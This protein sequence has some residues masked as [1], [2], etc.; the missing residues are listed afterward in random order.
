MTLQILPDAERLTV[1]WLR[2]QPE[3]AAIFDDRIYTEIPNSP[4][5]PLARVTRVAGGPT[6][7]LARLDSPLLQLDVWGGPKATA[8]DGIA[9]LLALMAGRMVGTHD[10]GV[11]SAVEVGG[12]SWLPDD[13]Y[14]PAR[15]RY[16]A[17]VRLWVHP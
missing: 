2:D 17:D 9:T 13:T 6:S 8:H 10:L 1:T 12:P 5:W 7:R 11:V 3:A 4:V 16:S 14:S 15:P